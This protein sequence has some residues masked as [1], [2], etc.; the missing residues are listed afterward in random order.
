[1]I[2]T[3]LVQMLLLLLLL[4]FRERALAYS[5]ELDN[6]IRMSRN[7]LPLFWR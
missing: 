6:Q 2:A 1:M 7:V 3:K 5:L 4:C